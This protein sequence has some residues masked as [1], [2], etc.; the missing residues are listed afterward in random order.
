MSQQ[1]ESSPYRLADHYL[2]N[3]LQSLESLKRQAEKA[4]DQLQ[5][6]DLF[7]LPDGESNSIALLIK[8]ITGNMRSRWTDFLTSDGEN[9]G[10]S[11]LLQDSAHFLKEIYGVT[12]DI[13]PPNRAY[14]SL[15]YLHRPKKS[16]CLVT[17]E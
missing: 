11:A 17:H 16:R 12:A 4:I 2:Q 7:W 1:N 6:Q 8:H 13:T 14:L 9:R 3:V 15:S 5:D 10:I